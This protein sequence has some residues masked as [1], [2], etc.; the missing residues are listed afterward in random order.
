MAVQIM[1]CLVELLVFVRKEKLLAAAA[2]AVAAVRM[3]ISTNQNKF[4]IIHFFSMENEQISFYVIMKKFYGRRKTLSRQ[5][6]VMTNS[7]Q[8][9]SFFGL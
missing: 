6:S 4:S 5:V 8:S 7:Y 2:V 1:M 3:L 9:H